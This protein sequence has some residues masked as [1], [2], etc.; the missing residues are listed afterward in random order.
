VGRQKPFND[1]PK[2]GSVRIE[3][4]NCL[5]RQVVS[6]IPR[7]SILSLI[8]AF[9]ITSIFLMQA[10]MAAFGLFPFAMRRL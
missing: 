7:H 10:M 1:A 9:C 3:V 2:V 8:M 5:V 4:S 6:G